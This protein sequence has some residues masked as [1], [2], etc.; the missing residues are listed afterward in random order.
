MNNSVEHTKSADEKILFHLEDDQWH[1]YATERLWAER[2]E[3]ERYRLRNAPFF[4]FGVSAEDVVLA[5]QESSGQLIFREVD[6]RGGHSTYRVII[7]RGVV[8]GDFEKSWKSLQ[9]L[10]CTYE[11]GPG[12]LRAIDVP[13]SADIYEVYQRLEAGE[14]AGV[15]DFEEG[16]CGH[17]LDR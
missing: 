12:R 8:L 17:P 14:D 11:E 4:V 6:A 1:G 5:T 10:G 15:W 3:D 7:A 2:L 13:P 16:H 9:D